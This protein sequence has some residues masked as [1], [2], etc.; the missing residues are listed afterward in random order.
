VTSTA[1]QIR[2]DTFGRAR[3]QQLAATLGVPVP[4]GNVVP[5]LWHW[6]MFQRWVAP[7]ALGADGHPGSD[8]FLPLQPDLPR[9]M[10][11]GTT[12][13]FVGDLPVD[14][15][16]ERV[17]RVAGEAEK[18][19]RSGRLRFV[20]VEHRYS[21]GGR[22]LLREL[23]HIVYRAAVSDTGAAAPTPVSASPPLARSALVSVDPVL[24]FRY[25]ALTGNG[26]RIHYD[27]DYARD[28]EGYPGLVIHGPLQATLLAGFAT[29][30]AF[31]HRRLATLD[32]RSV[33]P[34]FTTTAPLHVEGAETADGV[35]LQTRDASGAVCTTAD[36]TWA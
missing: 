3:L 25:S 30:E 20:T 26:H 13:E 17:S 33:R 5:P 16:I 28:V 10:A 14:A 8:D 2:R 32:V 9:R 22:L 24:L 12:F 19:G 11:A 23:Q 27:A 21:A 18:T 35:R 4:E 29:S 15:E 7:A 36:G 1:T 34:A 31:G 6:A